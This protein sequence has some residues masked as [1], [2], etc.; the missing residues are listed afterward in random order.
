VKPGGVLLYSTCTINPAENE[1][2]ARWI[3]ESFPLLLEEERQFMP[4]EDETDG[5][6]YARFRRRAK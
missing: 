4:G 1:E 6:Y 3:Q 5:F 2:M